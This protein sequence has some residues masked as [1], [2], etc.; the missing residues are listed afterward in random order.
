MIE[1]EN[2]K[3]QTILSILRPENATL[4]AFIDVLLR[5]TAQKVILSKITSKPTPTRSGIVTSARRFYPELQEEV[6]FQN[7]MSESLIILPPVLSMNRVPA[8]KAMKEINELL[9][10]DLEK[11]TM[12]TSFGILK[13]VGVDMLT[14]P[15]K[16]IRTTDNLFEISNLG[17]KP[18]KQGEWQIE[19]YYFA[20]PSSVS[21]PFDVS[22]ISS[23]Q[24]L[25]LGLSYCKEYLMYDYN[26]FEKVFHEGIDF[27][28]NDK[29]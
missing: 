16:K 23:S 21:A 15:S 29:R 14:E 3:I 11:K 2:K 5:Y 13:K 20:Q 17:Y 22:I 25:T 12:F 4:T 28:I 1:V 9:D 6:K 27:F 18:V 24:Y 19:K 10:R 8:F 7:F 26:E